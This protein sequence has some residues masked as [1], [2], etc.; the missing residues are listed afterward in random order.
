MFHIFSS[1]FF[2]FFLLFLIKK[3]TNEKC[4]FK[5]P[6]SEVVQISDDS[7]G[8][9]SFLVAEFCWLTFEKIHVSCIFSK[10]N[11]KKLATEKLKLPSESLDNFASIHA[12]FF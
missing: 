7:D 6:A 2:L 1:S 4:E 11:N 3:N 5:I 9:F 10:V 8:N 12:A